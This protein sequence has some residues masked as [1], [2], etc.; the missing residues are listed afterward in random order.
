[1][2]IDYGTTS[3][4]QQATALHHF[5]A[6]VP[7][8]LPLPAAAPPLPAAAPPPLPPRPAPLLAPPFLPCKQALRLAGIQYTP[9]PCQA[10]HNLM[11]AFSETELMQPG[12]LGW[13]KRQDHSSK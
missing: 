8:R 12:W 10:H 4:P 1:M 2:Q 7:T 11:T 9:I 3:G 13:L 6:P 5:F